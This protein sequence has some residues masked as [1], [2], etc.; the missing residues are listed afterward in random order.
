MDTMKLYM[1]LSEIDKD[2]RE[3]RLIDAHD[4]LY[5]LK[6]AALLEASRPQIKTAEFA[7]KY[8]ELK[9]GKKGKP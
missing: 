6:K 7:K 9:T 5:D 4:K 2:M 1:S 8:Q 3:W